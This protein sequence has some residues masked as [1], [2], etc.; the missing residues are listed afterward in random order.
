MKFQG[1][2]VKFSKNWGVAAPSAPLLQGTLIQFLFAPKF[3]SSWDSLYMFEL[4][5]EKGN[6]YDKR[7]QKVGQYIKSNIKCLRVNFVREEIQKKWATNSFKVRRNFDRWKVQKIRARQG[8]FDRE[9]VQNIWHYRYFSFKVWRSILK[10]RG[11]KNLGYIYFIERGYK[12][13]VITHAQA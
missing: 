12:K 8:Y 10:E 4:Q 5:S 1:E 2:W 11:Y 3:I 6:Y 7:V 13:L 9:G